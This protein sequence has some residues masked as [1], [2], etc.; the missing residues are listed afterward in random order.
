MLAEDLPDSLRPT[1]EFFDAE[2][3]N[4]A[5]SLQDNIL[6][7]KVA[8]GH[9]HASARVGE[10]I[11]EVVD[12]VD[13]RREVMAVGLDYQ[14]G[15]GGGRLGFGQRQKVA[16]GRALLKHPCLLILHDATASLDSASRAMLFDTVL[17]HTEGRGLV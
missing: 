1:I 4:A 14:V 17:E 15:I 5:A 12:A 3:Y 9:A 13:A 8:H 7:G 16:I 11:G 2:R 10:L 6:L